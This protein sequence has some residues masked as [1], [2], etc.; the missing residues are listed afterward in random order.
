VKKI[1]IVVFRYYLANSLSLI[2]SATLLAK[3]GYDVHIF[4]DRFFYERSKATFDEDNISVHPIDMSTDV[5]AHYPGNKTASKGWNAFIANIS[6]Q[7]N[8]KKLSSHASFLFRVIQLAYQNL[9]ATRLKLTDLILRLR[10]AYAS[11]D[12]MVNYTQQFFPFLVEFQQKIVKDLDEDYVC[13]V[14][15]E[16]FG[17]IA[18]TLAA[19][20]CKEK[21]SIPTIYYNQ[22]LLLEKECGR[23]ETRV[24]KSLE[25]L[26]NQ[27]CYLTIVQDKKRAKHLR[28]DNH[29][30]V[31]SIICVPVSGLAKP[32]H[33]KGEFLQKTYGIPSEKTVLLYAGN[34]E[35]WAMCLEMAEAA[36]NWNKDFVLVLHSWREDLK[37]DPY[38]NQ[39]RQLT[40]SGKVYLSL[41]DVDW[42]HMPEL[43]SS[44]DIGLVF[45]KRLGEN[46]YETGHSSN[47]LVQYLQVGLP[48]ITSDFPSLKDVVVRYQCGECANGPDDIEKCAG[49]IFDDYERYRA[50][51]FRCYESEYNFAKYFWKVIERIE[52]IEAPSS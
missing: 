47:K 12:T 22:E 14:G 13:L 43:L 34:L 38:V 3:E 25:R 46:F 28:D 19:N 16:P 21:R 33:A 27:A 4:I 37:N 7:L 15:V 9:Y 39:I 31:D 41:M 26:C 36:Q 8:D 52:K 32:N 18:A 24:L 29:L 6:A 35:S 20:A 1:A 10:Y 23:A 5:Y 40:H 50:N 42:Q 2:S 45:Y 51:S 30:D 48:V 17:L 49:K 44:A 11:I